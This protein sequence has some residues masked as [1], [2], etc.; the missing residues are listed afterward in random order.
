MSFLLCIPPGNP[1]RQMT[2]IPVCGWPRC[3]CAFLK[4][5]KKNMCVIITNL[6]VGRFPFF[7][8]RMSQ[9]KQQG[10]HSF[11][12]IQLLLLVV[13]WVSHSG[14]DVLI[15]AG[16]GTCRMQLWHDLGRWQLWQYL[17]GQVILPPLWNEVLW[18]PLV[19]T[20]LGVSGLGGK[21]F[22]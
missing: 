9:K 14:I 5:P 12:L 4:N 7:K 2:L 10:G 22:K 8:Q 13:P 11:E 6:C 16:S 17:M 19:K 3:R 18:D 15:G 20:S 21:L 1:A